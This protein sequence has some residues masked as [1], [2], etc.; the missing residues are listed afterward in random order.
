MRSGKRQQR[1][2]GSV[3]CPVTLKRRADIKDLL[4]FQGN[5]DCTDRITAAVYF[6][7]GIQKK[8][9]NKHILQGRA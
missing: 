1:R 5:T 8:L 7:A 4:S 9:K 3:F 6:P 2:T